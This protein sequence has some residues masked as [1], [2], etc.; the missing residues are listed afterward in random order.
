MKETGEYLGGGGVHAIQPETAE[1]G[2]WI[3]KSAHG[4]AY[5]REAVTALARWAF[6]SLSVRYL[7]YPVDRRN[8]ASR[9]IPE[10]LGARIEAEYPKVNAS[11]NVLDI[12]EYRVYRPAQ[13]LT[14]SSAAESRG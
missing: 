1:L 9:K 14:S 4:N 10:S 2:I 6:E 5:G 8:L 3:K 13:S 7:I 11:G 12:V